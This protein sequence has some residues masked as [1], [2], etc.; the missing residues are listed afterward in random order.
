VIRA[1]LASLLAIVAVAA[2]PATALAQNAGG[3]QYTDPLSHHTPT[4]HTSSSGGS[5]H[6][7]SSSSSGTTSGSSVAQASAS[8]GSGTTA[9]S[10]SSSGLPRTG[11]P[12]GFLSFA[13]AI[14]VS[15][16][17]GLRRVVYGSRS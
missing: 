6:T 1:P 5:G 16:G 14:L 10:G 13:G 8:T 3:D 4:S 7:S 2:A 15:L 9:A 12:V 11:F 17:L